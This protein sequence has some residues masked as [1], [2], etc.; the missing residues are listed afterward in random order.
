MYLR[1]LQLA[2][3]F[4][5]DV[6]GSGGNP[7]APKPGPKD[8]ETFSVDY[9]RELRAENKGYRLRASEMEKTANDAKA[10]AEKATA[11]LAA[12]NEKATKDTADAV[13]AANTAAAQRLIRAEVKA[14]AIQAGLGHLDYLKLL[15]LSAITVGEDGEVVVPADF[16]TAAKAASPHLFA[17]TGADRGTT[18][19]PGQPPK[20][21]PP[22]TKH[23][24][25][26]T[27][28]EADAALAAL[29]GRR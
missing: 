15:D 13:K 18:T 22:G 17:A 24:S 14:G 7:P 4:S 5:T 26:M 2:R 6:E 27:D 12:A 19:N 16:W 20:P 10:V 29:T 28:A 25:Q 11:D 9:V 23:A 1:H 21:T 8:P 3:L